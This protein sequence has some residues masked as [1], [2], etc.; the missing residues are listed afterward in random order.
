MSPAEVGARVR[1]RFCE[2]TDARGFDGAVGDRLDAP[3]P[4]PRL[5]DAAAAP[6]VLREALRREAREILA[7]RWKAFGHVP[8]QVDDPPRWD[9]DYRAGVDLETTR[10]AFD[11]N[12]RSLPGGADIKMIWELSRWYQLVRLAQAFWVLHDEAAAR[13]CLAW[14]GDWER[15]NPPYRGWNWTSALES[16]LRLVQ[17]TWID[18]LLA[19]RAKAC[20]WEVQLEELRRRILPA[21]VWSTWRHRSFGSSANNHILGELTGLVLATARWRSLERWGETL[22]RL[23]ALWEREVLAQFAADGGNREQALNY[24]LFSW[25]LCWQTRTALRAAGRTVSAEVEERLRRAQEFFLDVQV[26][27]EP[28]DYGDS[29]GAYATPFF[30]AEDTSAREWRDWFMAPERSPAIEY[31]WGDEPRPGGPVR[32]PRE[33]EWQIYAESGMAVHRSADWVLRWDLSPLG[34]LKTAAH[35]HLDALHLSFWWGGSALVIDPGTGA[36]FVDPWLRAHL[37]S[38]AAHNGPRPVGLDFPKRLGPFLW[39]EHHEKPVWKATAGGGLAAE[40]VLPGGKARRE[41]KR[42]AERNGWE[43]SDSFAPAGA[44]GEFFVHWQFAPGTLV[45]PLGERVFAVS[46]PGW[47]VAVEVGLGWDQVEWVES[48]RGEERLGT[49]SPGFRAVAFGPCLRLRASSHKPCVFKTAFLA[50]I[51]S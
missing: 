24:H 27:S 3:A 47:R 31:W 45:E 34:Y 12:Y 10:P 33:G 15:C 26:E 36:Y 25:E 48:P 20:G 4:F 5:R 39:S 8:I 46:Q 41:V 23:Q 30:A 16:G 51:P 38:G 1:K 50:S 40:L 29:D 13:Q 21:H 44:R 28:W 42:L 7:G 6:A 2:R 11:L 37:A 14:L 18:A 9:R 17:F 19:P 49:C 22:E 35:G 32:L 43:I